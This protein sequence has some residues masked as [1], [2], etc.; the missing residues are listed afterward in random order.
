MANERDTSGLSDQADRLPGH[1]INGD[2]DIVEERPTSACSRRGRFASTKLNRGVGPQS[3]AA[4]YL[5]T[6]IRLDT[7]KVLYEIRQTDVFSQWLTRLRD[8][9]ALA[10]II[11][12]LESAR[13]GNLGDVKSVG[14]G[15]REMRIHV[16]PGYRIYFVQ[17][18][19]VV[20]LLLCGGDKATQRRDIEKAKT[21]LGEVGEG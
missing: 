11:A 7:V 1:S 13:L 21:L 18:G 12:R 6:R 9:K 3:A 5:T 17:T 10:R 19:Q 4:P 20:L 8:K 15:V 16:G 14:G 2:N